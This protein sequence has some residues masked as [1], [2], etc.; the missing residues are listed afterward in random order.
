MFGIFW[1]ASCN[2]CF[3]SELLYFTNL[4]LHSHTTVRL[5][6]DSFQNKKQNKTKKVS[7]WM[8]QNQRKCYFFQA[9]FHVKT[10]R[11]HYP[12]CNVTNN[13]LVRDLTVQTSIK[14]K[15]YNSTLMVDIYNI[16][17]NILT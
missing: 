16:I 1:T 3:S 8:Q 14:R 5:M 12:Q 11:F 15:E 6:M 13:N 9:I 4:A 2:Y 7:K 10:W 17:C